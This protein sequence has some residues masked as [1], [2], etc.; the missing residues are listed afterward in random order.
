MPGHCH[1]GPIPDIWQSDIQRLRS[2]WEIVCVTFH[3]PESLHNMS[4]VWTQHSSWF[5]SDY[6]TFLDASWQLHSCVL[7]VWWQKS[8]LFVCIEILL[9]FDGQE[10]NSL[11]LEKTTKCFCWRDQSPKYTI[12]LPLMFSV[13]SAFP[14]ILTVVPIVRRPSFHLIKYPT[15]HPEKSLSTIWYGTKPQI[16]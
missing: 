16:K 14:Q 1:Q 7:N 4:F 10:I 9:R 3:T 6:E 13:T 11:M 15:N 8:L 12:F 5:V 2:N